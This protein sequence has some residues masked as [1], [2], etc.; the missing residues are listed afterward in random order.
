[1]RVRIANG[2]L[3]VDLEQEGGYAP[4]ILA[5]LVNRAFDLWCWLGQNVDDETA[6]IDQ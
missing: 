5:D 6:E 1:M 3:D 4:D 2:D